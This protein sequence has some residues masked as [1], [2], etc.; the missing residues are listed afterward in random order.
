MPISTPLG[1]VHV[2]FLYADDV[3]CLPGGLRAARTAE[4]RR[5]RLRREFA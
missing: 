2:L 3:A 5:G 1:D 4:A